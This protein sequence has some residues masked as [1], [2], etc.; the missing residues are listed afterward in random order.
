MARRGAGCSSR[1][2][3]FIG[4]GKTYD[5][6][7]DKLKVI[8]TARG[9]RVTADAW[10]LEIGAPNGQMLQVGE[11]LNAKR[12]AFSGASPGLDFFGQGRGSGKIAG[13]FVVWELELDGEQ[14]TRLAVDFVQRAEEKGQPLHGKLRF[15]S[16][17][18]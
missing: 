4:Q 5:Y 12:F 16:M 3:D 10:T 18:Q 13:E 1:P 2:S 15:N 14:I 11:Y 6:A 7:G 8:K 9:V 17:L